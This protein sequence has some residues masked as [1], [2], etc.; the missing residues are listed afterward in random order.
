MGKCIPKLFDTR[1][2]LMGGWGGLPWEI[3]VELHGNYFHR[4]TRDGSTRQ[5]FVQGLRSPWTFVNSVSGRNHRPNRGF[6][7]QSEFR[8]RPPSE[9]TGRSK[10]SEAVS[11][12]TLGMY[13]PNLSQLN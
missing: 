10:N 4:R 13:E 11:K 2:V 5:I 8:S 9:W 3:G 1:Q 12:T 6:E 7:C